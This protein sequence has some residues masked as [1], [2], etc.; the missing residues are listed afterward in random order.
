V[1]SLILLLASV[2]IIVPPFTCLV[3][4]SCVITFLPSV[5]SSQFVSG[6]LFFSSLRLSLCVALCR[7]SVSL[8]CFAPQTLPCFIFYFTLTNCYLIS[9]LWFHFSLLH[10][11]PSAFINLTSS[12]FTHLSFLLHSPSP[13]MS[14]QYVWHLCHFLCSVSLHTAVLVSYL[15]PSDLTNMNSTIRTQFNAMCEIGLVFY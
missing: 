15:V 9:L 5:C 7:G 8:P 13:Y 6:S 1:I 10:C 2:E 11:L 14:L 4:A 12:Y 3:P